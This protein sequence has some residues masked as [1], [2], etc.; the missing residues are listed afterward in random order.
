ML[1]TNKPAI[2]LQIGPN[3]AY[4]YLKNIKFILLIEFYSFVC[5]GVCYS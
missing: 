5:L 3:W 4:F 2:I 1:T